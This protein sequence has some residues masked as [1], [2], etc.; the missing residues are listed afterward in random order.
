M[1]RS[2]VLLTLALA[3]G[4]LAN[5]AVRPDPCPFAVDL[6]SPRSAYHTASANAELVA[7][8]ATAATTATAASRRRRPGTAPSN[9]QGTPLPR[10]NFVDTDLFSKM[11]KDG[12]KRSEERRVGKECRSRWSPYH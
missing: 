4:L 10:V 11:D 12:V 5:A 3:P 7:P 1:K 6:I 8:S 2:L 9:P